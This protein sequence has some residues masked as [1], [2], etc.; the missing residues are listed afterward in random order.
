MPEP[1]FWDGVYQGRYPLEAELAMNDRWPLT[2]DVMEVL[3]VAAP[4]VFKVLESGCGAGK[5]NFYLAGRLPYP[6]Q[7]VGV[8]FSGPALSAAARFKREGGDRYARV[9]FARGDAARLPIAGGIFDRVLSLGV[10]GH[11]QDPVPAVREIARVLK[12]G[13]LCFADVVNA[14]PLYRWRRRWDPLGGFERNSSPEEL[15]G[16]FR[17]AGLEVVRAYAKDPVF[18]WFTSLKPPERLKAAR[19]W[20]YHPWWW[21]AVVLKRLAAPLARARSHRGFYSVVVARKGGA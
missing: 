19:P 18:A 2:P 15:A 13:G 21:I 9:H 10:L 16:W 3:P 17:E 14:T 8:D 4:G 11:L 12:P 1:A 20:L 5:W 7:A 6:V